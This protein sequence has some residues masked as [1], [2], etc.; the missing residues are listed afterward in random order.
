MEAGSLYKCYLAYLIL[1]QVLLLVGDLYLFFAGQ[2]TVSA[3]LRLHRTWYD[4]TL[5]VVLLANTL[6]FIHLFVA[7]VPPP[8]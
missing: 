5:A 3:W 7:T 6:L 2:P 4:Y 1:G 8:R